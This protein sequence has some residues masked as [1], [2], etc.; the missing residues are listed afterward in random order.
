MSANTKKLT[1]TDLIKNKEKYQVKSDTTE[2]LFVER[3]G[4]TI[5]IRK[6]E[7]S[8]CLEAFEMVNDDAQAAKADP[9]MVYNIVV[10]PNL[11]DPN[12]QKEFGCVEPDD[13]VEKLFESGEISNI[14]QIGMELAGYKSGVKKVNDLKN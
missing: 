14:A 3:L 1:L 4:A 8:L 7:R 2:E 12:L 9:F 5:T 11:K 13:I 10:E 6:P